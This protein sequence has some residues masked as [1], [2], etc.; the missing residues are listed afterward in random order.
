MAYYQRMGVTVPDPFRNPTGTWGTDE[1]AQECHSFVREVL[2]K[3]FAGWTK[4]ETPVLG[5]AVLY[6]S[7]GNVPDHIGVLIEP[8]RMMHA[9]ERTGVVV[10]RIDRAP[11]PNRFIGAYAFTG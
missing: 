11:W 9:L 8:G 4:L 6:C 5:C 3:H 2:V 10:T 1:P 7:R